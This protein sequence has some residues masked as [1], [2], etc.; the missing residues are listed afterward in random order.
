MSIL[1]RFTIIH[2]RELVSNSSLPL[3]IKDMNSSRLICCRP[4]PEFN[5]LQ[6]FFPELSEA[7]VKVSVFVGRQMKKTVGCKELPK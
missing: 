7:K 1:S 6:D 2:F 3:N 5:Y 4:S